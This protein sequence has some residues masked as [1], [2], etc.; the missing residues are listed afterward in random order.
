VF[1]RELAT[2]LSVS[3]ITGEFL[4]RRRGKW[5]S[6]VRSLVSFFIRSLAN[7]CVLIRLKTFQSL[8]NIFMIDSRPLSLVWASLCRLEFSTDATFVFVDV[9]FP[10]MRLGGLAWTGCSAGVF[11]V[12]ALIRSTVYRIYIQTRY[13]QIRWL[14]RE[15]AA[16]RWLSACTVFQPWPRAPSR[17]G[18]FKDR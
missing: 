14:Y 16:I 18:C 10:Q 6:A 12:R 13:I 9:I 8:Q 1:F 2:S 15:A 7:Y 11:H 4:N 5:R 3:D 17:C